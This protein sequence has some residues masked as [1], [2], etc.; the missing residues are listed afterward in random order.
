MSPECRRELQFFVR[1]ATKLGMKDLVLPLLYV[2]VPELNSDQSTDDLVNLVREFQWVDWRDLRFSDRTSEPYRRAVVRLVTRLI[3]VNRQD[4]SLG[5]SESG[6]SGPATVV[7]ADD[8][9]GM[10]DLLATTEESLPMLASTL[11]LISQEIQ[12]I[13][14]VM[15]EGSEHIRNADSQGKGYAARLLV[16]RKVAA[17]LKEPVARLELSANRFA[18]QLHDVDQ[19]FRI[20]IDQAPMAIEDDPES[21]EGVCTFFQSV[22]GMSSAAHT[23]FASVKSMIDNIEPI[24][25]LSRDLRPTLRRL[26]QA[27]TVMVEGREVINEWVTLIEG[28]GVECEIS[29]E[30]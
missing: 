12:I 6:S 17:R 15:N 4:P 21:K 19:G 23:S 27:L 26:R 22:K 18:S 1:K 14:Q 8:E 30:Q 9:P 24:E 5:E 20:M 28:S 16:A 25:K 10:I 7:N 11:D 2:D 29:D 3:E 13:G